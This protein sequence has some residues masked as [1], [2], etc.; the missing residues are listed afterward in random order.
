MASAQHCRR[1]YRPAV[2]PLEGRML[3]SAGDLDPTFGTGGQLT[4]GF[5]LP[6]DS[7]AV[8]T[9]VQADG[10]IVVVGQVNGITLALSRYLPDGSLD[11]SFGTDGR[12]LAVGDIPPCGVAVQPDGKI[13]VATT[14][15]LLNPD[16]HLPGQK[17]F[18]VLRYNADGS[19]NNSWT[20]AFGSI[21]A[22]AAAILVQPDG[23]IL[24]VGDAGMARYTP[25]GNPDPGFG[26][27]GETT[28]A[29]GA[30][31]ALQP[32]GKL[33]VAGPNGVGRY[34]ADGSLDTTFGTNGF[35]TNSAAGAQAAV[36]V[37]PDGKIVVGQ[38]VVELATNTDALAVSRYNADGSPDAGFG[39]QG[40]T[41]TAT[42]GNLSSTVSGLVLEGTGRIVV[43][44]AVNNGSP[45]LVLFGYT[46]AGALDGG[47]GTGGRVATPLTASGLSGTE[48]LALDGSNLVVVGQILGPAAEDFGVSRYTASGI[49]DAT[50]G[51][52]GTV[53]TDIPVAVDATAAGAVL[54]GDGKLIVAGT[55]SGVS[56]LDGS[57]V[58]LVRYNPDGSL[59][60]GFGTGGRVTTHTAAGA[61]DAAGAVGVQP[62]GRIIVAGSSLVAPD[63]ER[64]LLVG[65][66]PD[67]RL[68]PTF[69]TGGEVLTEVS[70]GGFAGTLSASSTPLAIA[71]DG[72][73][74]VG[75]N[76]GSGPGTVGFVVRYTADGRLEFGPVDVPLSGAKGMQL[77]ADG[78]LVVVGPEKA[79][80]AVPLNLAVTRLN[81]NGTVDTSFGTDGVT[82][83]TL[84]TATNSAGA[85]TL[86]PDGKILVAGSSAGGF[87]MGVVRYL[88]GGQ[89][90]PTF[91]SA[92]LSDP[93]G[94]SAPASKAVV[95]Q[96][97][98][99]I[100]VAGASPSAFGTLA[101]VAVLAPDGSPDTAFGTG[102]T[103][104][105]D[106][107]T[108]DSPIAVLYQPDGKLVVLGTNFVP[109]SKRTFALARYQADT[110]SPVVPLYDTE[111]F[112]DAVYHD[113]LNRVPT[114]AELQAVEAPLDAARFP[115]LSSVALGYVTS[116]EGRGDV[117][118]GYYQQYLG[119]SAGPGEIQL[120]LPPQQ[121]LSPDQVLPLILGSA[122]YFQK[123]GSDN[124]QWLA[125]VYHD[126]LGRAPDP[127][128]Q[129]WLDAL[130]RGAP[131]DQVAALIAASTEYRGDVIAQ[132]Y[133]TDLGRSAGAGDIAVWLPALAQPAPPGGGPSPREQFRAGVLASP[134]YFHAHGNS[135]PGWVDSLYT[136]LLG[137]LPD[138][139]GA[140]ATL[141][142]VVTG[143]AGARQAAAAAV[144]AGM[145]YQRDLVSGYSDT[146]LERSASPGEID[147]WVQLL[148]QGATDEQVLALI[149]SSDEFYH[150]RAG[151]TDA[152]WLDELYF[153]LLGRSRNGDNSLLGAIAPPGSRVLVATAILTSPEYR[154]HLVQTF[155][156]TYLNRTPAPGETAGW[157]QL[158]AQGT[159][160]EGVLAGILGSEEYLLRPR[161][162]S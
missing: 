144:L 147:G 97:N 82:V 108:S 72:E 91:G 96:P 23:R 142:A 61:L 68:D 78:K 62:G 30:A 101:N 133:A 39:T 114:A 76:R 56:N 35:A 63:S 43:A 99:L 109:P 105:I 41:T 137:R 57:L 19:L 100:V 131:R 153:R 116:P 110:A 52:G 123:H 145:E 150:N 84:N 120:W 38:N 54:L 92:G 8:A 107:V 7:T 86:Q 53:A 22:V 112:A 115:V 121:N 104:S 2:E 135:N 134:E 14:G 124:A 111:R 118:A 48:A 157:V 46:S 58:G 47:F 119:R 75:G 80:T 74:T 26:S 161:R 6:H 10:K 132:V 44:D 11:A 69:G 102:G 31:L 140:A 88:P 94:L 67:G 158:L 85:V 59:D 28:D 36:A 106:F 149:V 83:T 50:F 126:L 71:P 9:A 159:S 113:V 143:Y 49:P 34:N 73:I 146:Y 93:F 160:D 17:V 18:E 21:N 33:L 151:G 127:G 12:V 155:Y 15:S 98:G 136:H 122:E 117:I 128:S 152:T 77:Q 40:T 64:L 90:D 4:T 1:F 60:T 87:Q 81:N 95:V 65:Y 42:G 16:P 37:Q 66:L 156:Q 89:A 103:V 138:A 162:L 20:T 130:N 27:G 79:A 139:P 70:G 3:L 141:Q 51:S 29:A 32:D 25:D 154:Q 5:M 148:R 45:S 13:V 125:G 24:V 129:P 55:V